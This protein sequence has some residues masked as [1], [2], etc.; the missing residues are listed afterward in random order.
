MRKH[1]TLF[2]HINCRVVR[3]LS[4]YV[5]RLFASNNLSIVT[6]DGVISLTVILKLLRCVITMM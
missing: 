1:H 5:T 4:V 3:V 6:G 2:A